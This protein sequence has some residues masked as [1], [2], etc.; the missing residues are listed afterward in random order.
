MH[1][2]IDQLNSLNDAKSLEIL[3]KDKKVETLT[4][5]N[6]HLKNIQN[7]LKNRIGQLKMSADNV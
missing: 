6:E 4:F 7:D 2:K 3:D 5:E 1:D